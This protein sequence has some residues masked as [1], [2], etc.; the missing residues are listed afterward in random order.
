MAHPAGGNIEAI[1]KAVKEGAEVLRNGAEH[2]KDAKPIAAEAADKVFAQ[3]KEAKGKFSLQVLKE[4]VTK[5]HGIMAAG[6]VVAADGV[7]RA[8]KRDEDGERHLVRGV[9]Q[10]AIGAG[11]FAAALA[12]QR[13]KTPGSHEL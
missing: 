5:E 10:T 2:V 1:S 3:L 4:N 9:V 7:R 13:N 11:T 6:A 12:V 8:V